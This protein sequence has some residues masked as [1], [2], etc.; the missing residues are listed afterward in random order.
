MKEEKKNIQNKIKSFSKD[1]LVKHANL[2]PT[3]YSK[4]IRQNKNIDRCS[5]NLPK[6]EIMTTIL[7]PQILSLYANYSADQQTQT[8][9]TY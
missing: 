9:S 3:D 1:D 6:P 2:A 7:T 8:L 5:A 4:W